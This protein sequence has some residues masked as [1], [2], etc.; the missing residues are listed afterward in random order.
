MA[1]LFVPATRSGDATTLDEREWSRRPLDSDTTVVRDARLLRA[2][3]PDGEC[4]VVVGAASV[5]VNGDALGTGIAVLRDRDE[6]FVAGVRVYFSAET[7]AVV[8][9]FPG[10]EGAVLCARCTTPMVAGAPAVRCPDCGAWQHQTDE[11]P[12]W[13]YAER[14]AR[15]PRATALDADYAWTPEGL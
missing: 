12:C 2:A 3:T 4:W 15:C 14:C 8:A 9:A 6:L 13:I 1:H 7:L 11:L 5:R 10:G